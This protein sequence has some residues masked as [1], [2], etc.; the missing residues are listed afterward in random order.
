MNA[1]I[2][3]AVAAGVH[4]VVAAGNDDDDACKHS[5]A[6]CED[7][8]TAGASDIKDTRAGFSNQGPCTDVSAPGVDVLSSWIG[9]SKAKLV[10]SGTS[11]ATPHVA[12]LIAYYLSLARNTSSALHSGT[13]SSKEMKEFVIARATKDMLTDLHSDTPNLLVYNSVDDVDRG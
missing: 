8:I 2:A 7:A 5:P 4:I 10:G 3:N 11:M 13:I 12:G 1:A 9:S 6:S